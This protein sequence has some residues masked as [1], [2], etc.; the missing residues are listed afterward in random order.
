MSTIFTWPLAPVRGLVRLAELIQEQ[1]DR[2]LH[3]PAAVRRKLE[4][5]EAAREAGEITEE[6]ERRA[7]EQ[8]LQG[9]MRR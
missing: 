9:A 8:V 1:A 6:E 7:V 5:I 3:N 4:E 2:E